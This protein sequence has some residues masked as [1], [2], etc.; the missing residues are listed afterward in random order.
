MISGYLRNYPDTIRPALDIVGTAEGVKKVAGL[1]VVM[2]ANG[3]VFFADTTINVNPTSEQ[4]AD[5]AELTANSV[6][7]LGI[8]PNI[9]MLSYSNFGSTSDEN[10]KKVRNA[11]TILHERRPDLIVDGEIQ[12]NFAVNKKALKDKFPFS[13]LV[14]KQVNVLI[15]PT[16]ESGNIAYKLLQ[17]LSG[18]ETI[19]PILIGLKKQFIFFNLVLV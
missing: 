18:F 4:L 17:E 13:D 11:V 10:S 1:Y 2:T 9:A 15:F 8:K 6:S 5:I 16:L 3:P 19:G 14:N 12:A 7:R